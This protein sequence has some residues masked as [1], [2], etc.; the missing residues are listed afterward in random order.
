MDHGTHRR[1]RASIPDAVTFST[2]T[3]QAAALLLDARSTGGLQSLS[4]GSARRIGTMPAADLVSAAGI[5]QTLATVGAPID[6]PMTALGDRVAATTSLELDGIA[7]SVAVL[8][9]G[10]VSGSELL[11]GKVIGRSAALGQLHLPTAVQFGRHKSTSVGDLRIAAAAAVRDPTH[12]PSALEPI[13]TSLR[14]RLRGDWRVSVAV[15]GRVATQ[16]S[17]A[18][19]LLPLLEGWN[20]PAR[21]QRPSEANL[22][23]N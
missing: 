5:I 19:E 6:E 3:S 17:E 15:V 7:T 14:A 20:G 16:T 18:T 22:T 10:G 21:L 12:P 8:V 23:L 4:S 1:S 2:F 9:N 13:L 11:P